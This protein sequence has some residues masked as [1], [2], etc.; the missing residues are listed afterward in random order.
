MIRAMLLVLFATGLAGCVN[1]FHR[2]DTAPPDNN[3]IPFNGMR[4]YLQ[5]Y[6]SLHVIQV[7]G[8][9][10]HSAGNDCANGSENLR[11]QDEIAKRLGYALMDDY[12]HQ[13]PVPIQMNGGV[14]GSY[15]SRLY[16]GDGRNLYFSCVTW[17]ET[18]RIVKQGMLELDDEFLER[19][20]N[21]RHRAMINRSAKKFVNR[22]FSDPIIYL[23]TLGPFIREIVWKGIQGSTEQHQQKH[24]GLEL[25]QADSMSRLAASARFFAEVPVAIISDSLGSRIVFDVVCTKGSANC[26]NGANMEFESDKDRS[27]AEIRLANNLGASVRSVYMLANQLPL[28]ELAYIPPPPPGTSLDKMI[29]R[30]GTCYQPLLGLG[31]ADMAATGTATQEDPRR[32]PMQSV[33]LIAFTDVNDALSYHLTDRFK[34]RCAS[35]TGKLEGPAL[36]VKIVNVT[37]PNAKLRWLFVYSDLAGAHS[38]GFKTNPRAITYLVEGVH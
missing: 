13:A 29:E 38:S 12:G 22:S 35:A 9:G 5:A 28:L 17:G 27:P 6:G 20:E 19:N 37:M 25:A 1:T 4:D 23:G 14:A 21:E 3:P 24:F 10:D 7:H 26:Q 16:S 36:P 11:L 18:G 33:E 8:M 31:E 15:S 2:V 30:S 32:Q 34:Q